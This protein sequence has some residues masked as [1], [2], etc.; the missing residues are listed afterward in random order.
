VLLCGLILLRPAQGQEVFA[1]DQKAKP[2]YPKAEPAVSSDHAKTVAVQ[3]EK[4]K[5]PTQPAAA[6]PATVAKNAKQNVTGSETVKNV[7]TKASEPAKKSATVPAATPK[8]QKTAALA[9][10]TASPAPKNASVVTNAPVKQ[11]SATEQIHPAQATKAIG[12][13]PDTVEDA[14]ATKTPSSS[15]DFA[16]HEAA[17]FQNKKS[18]AEMK[19]AGDA[20]K[21]TVAASSAQPKKSIVAKPDK[22]EDAPATKTPSSSTDSAKHE[23]AISQPAKKAATEVKTA[24]DSPKVATIAVRSSMMESVS[25]KKAPS[26]SADS[27]KH[28]AAGSQSTKKAAIEAKAAG[29]A[30]KSP[31]VAVQPQ[32]TRDQKSASASVDPVTAKSVKLVNPIAENTSTVSINDHFDTA[33]TKLADG[34]DFP[35]GKPDAQGYYKARGFRSHGHMGE[36]WDGVRGGDTDLG[37]PIYS[38][39][40]GL[41]VFARDCHMGWGNVVIV[42][43]SYREGGTVKNVD[44]LYGHLNNMLVHRGQAVARGQKIATMG[45][46]HGLYDAHLHLEIRKNLE[47]GMSRAAFAQDFSNYYDPSQFIQAHRRL[48]AGGGTYRVA[49]NTFTRDANI[50]WDKTRN[51][52]HAH[53][54]GGSR[55]SAAALKR[56]VAAKH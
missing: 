24:G 55:E 6:T 36:D 19:A 41:V 40:D 18:A 16:K 46:A 31:A 34:F 1:G 5:T 9:K 20:Q 2:K 30:P 10:A 21:P 43:H 28:D 56:A 47:I 50:K 7:A 52:S 13:K 45:T 39:G 26:S 42:R 23:V 8:E 44:A 53:T 25:A 22:M 38:I 27:A 4:A 37:D 51:Y 12:A 17:I 15:T 54:G 35:V 3:S 29:D 49:M 33:F 14:P 48:S 11:S 32:T